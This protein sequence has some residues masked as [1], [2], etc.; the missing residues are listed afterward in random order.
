MFLS[1][2]PF[3]YKEL[4]MKTTPQLLFNGETPTNLQA[5]DVM[6]FEKKSAC[7]VILRPNQGS[8]YTDPSDNKHFLGKNL[9]L[10]AES[11]IAKLAGVLS[12][13]RIRSI[14]LENYPNDTVYEFY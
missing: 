6:V 10:V 14:C 9:N 11:A 1:N 12:G 2:K 7:I 8:L 5:G 4:T 13:L 3:F